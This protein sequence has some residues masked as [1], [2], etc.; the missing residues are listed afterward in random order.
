[1]QEDP[2]YF[3]EM[4]HLCSDLNIKN[5]S[6]IGLSDSSNTSNMNLNN[7][8]IISGGEIDDLFNKLSKP[9]NYKMT[10]VVRKDLNMSVGKIAAQVGHAVLNCYKEALYL[11]NNYVKNWENSGSAKI[12]LQVN[13][14]KELNEIKELAKLNKLPYAMIADAGRTEVE[15][16]TVTVISIGPGPVDEVDKVTGRLELLK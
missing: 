8:K 16:G 11:N 7:K 5:T 13:S 2:K 4:K 6:N 15:P 12:V 9:T 1:M 14:L 10:I 3:Q